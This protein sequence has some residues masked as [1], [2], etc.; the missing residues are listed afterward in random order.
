[1]AI[2]RITSQQRPCIR[3]ELNVVLVIAL[4]IRDLVSS[5]WKAFRATLTRRQL[6]SGSH[7]ATRN[8][9]APTS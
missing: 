9:L 1:M 7:T 3:G 5:A 6:V 4:E 2:Q 8:T